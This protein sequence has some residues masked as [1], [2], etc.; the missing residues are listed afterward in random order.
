[1]NLTIYVLKEKEIDYDCNTYWNNIKT[2]VFPNEARDWK[3]S[4]QPYW[5]SRDF[6]IMQVEIPDNFI[7]EKSK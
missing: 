4:A 7:M 1:M 2:T 5:C 3:E 6:D